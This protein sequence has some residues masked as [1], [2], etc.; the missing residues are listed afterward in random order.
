M[1]KNTS[2][3]TRT[4]REKYLLSQTDNWILDK[5][6]KYV[7]YQPQL[8]LPYENILDKYADYFEKYLIEVNI[9]SKYFKRPSM[10]AEY[11]YGDP[12]MDWLILYFAKIPSLFQFTKRKIKILPVDKLADLNQVFLSNKSDIEANHS[13]PL[14][15]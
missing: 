9:D 15:Y 7:K 6:M 10:Y 12:S 3:D 4:V 1:Y 2:N 11:Y 13:N 8:I 14:E 5:V